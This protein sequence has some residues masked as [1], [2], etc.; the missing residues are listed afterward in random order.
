MSHRESTPHAVATSFRD[1]LE[2]AGEKASDILGA[3]DLGKFGSA[4][5][6]AAT[7]MRHQLSSLPS[8]D[9]VRRAK[10]RG[11]RHVHH[12]AEAMGEQARRVDPTLEPKRRW[13]KVVVLLLMTGG[14]GLAVRRALTRGATQPSPS[15][16]DGDRYS[17]NVQPSPVR[18]AEADDA[19]DG[20]HSPDSNGSKPKTTAKATAK[21][22]GAAPG[23]NGASRPRA[24]A[25][26]PTRPTDT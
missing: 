3:A 2:S 18:I 17:A 9:G 6:G 25:K 5:L 10:R 21:D 23:S 20:P 12:L 13:R 8:S 22:T 24:A 14:A 4:G 26:K 15:T 7:E 19:A 16:A 11:A 1:A